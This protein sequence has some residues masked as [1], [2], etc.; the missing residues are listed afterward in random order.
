M[1]TLLY[2][3]QSGQGIE[4]NK[5]EGAKTRARPSSI[6]QRKGER[7]KKFRSGNE[8]RSINQSAYLPCV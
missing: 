3:V 1:K 6:S 8:V 2:R 4:S 7:K 5:G